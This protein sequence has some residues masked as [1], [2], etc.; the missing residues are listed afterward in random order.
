MEE[1]Q[2]S[3]KKKLSKGQ[4]LGWKHVSEYEHLRLRSLPA[5]GEKL[6]V[7]TEDPFSHNKLVP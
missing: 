2:L 7:Y 4:R 5:K 1:W 6:E 3:R